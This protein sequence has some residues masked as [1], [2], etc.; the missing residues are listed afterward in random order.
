[1]FNLNKEKARELWVDALC[2]GDYAQGRH[3]LA[4][5]DLGSEVTEYCCLGVACDLFQEYEDEGLDIQQECVHPNSIAWSYDGYSSSC[6][7]Q[8]QKWLGLTTRFGDHKVSHKDG[9]VDHRDL[10]ELND[11]DKMC[12]DEIA[13]VILSKPEGLFI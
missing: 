12:F 9:Y 8:V 13:E 10:A 4:R 1:M 3:A 11:D 7:P 6:P 5:F 2:S